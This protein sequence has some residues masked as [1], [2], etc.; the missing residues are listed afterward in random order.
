M[1][2]EA[3]ITFTSDIVSA[4]VSKNSVAVSDLPGLIQS[5]YMALLNAGEPAPVV[6]AKRE[7]AVSVRLSV[8]HDAVTCMEC[9]FKGKMLKR[10]L[11]TDHGLTPQDYRARWDL[12]ST[13]PIV[14]PAY[15]AKRADIAK[16]SGLGRKT[17]KKAGAKATSH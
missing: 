6:E 7:P 14:A 11:M 10:H 4:H 3:L 13:H 9:G 1:D 16:A 8:R 5:V 15:A 2:N 12:P 17:V